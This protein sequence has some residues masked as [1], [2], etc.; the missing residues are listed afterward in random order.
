M[1][2]AERR[3]VWLGRQTAS[4]I[5]VGSVGGSF[6]VRVVNELV[7]LRLGPG[8]FVD[9]GVGLDLLVAVLMYSAALWWSRPISRLLDHGEEGRRETARARFRGF[10][11]FLC[12]MWA[13]GAAVEGLWG[14]RLN[15]GARWQ[16]VLLPWFVGAWYGAYFSVLFM[17]PLLIS[18]VGG[19]LYGEPEIFHR[20]TGPSWSVRAKLGLLVLNLILVPL[21]LVEAARRA[22]VEPSKTAAMV[23]TTLVFAVGYLEVLY[24]GITKPLDGLVDKMRLVAAGDYS[25]KAT[26]LDDDEIGQLK[27]YFNDMVDGLAERERIK[28]TFGR[29]VSVEVAK[30]LIA[31]GTVSLGGESIEATVLFSDIRDFTP[32]CEGLPPEELVRLLNSYFSFVAEPIMENRGMVNKFIGDAVMAVFAKQFGSSEH[33]DDAVRAALGMRERLA[34]FNAHEKRDL[35]FGVGIHTGILVAG[36]I[37]TPKRLE[38]TVIG[39]TVNIAS[40]IESTNKELGSVI[41]V[42][43]DAYARLSPDLRASLKATRR[44]DIRLKGKEKPVALWSI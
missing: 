9:P 36:N 33:P 8:S 13:V 4:A 25:A 35:R 7:Y 2:D 12:A 43:E 26:V 22:G 41:L 29:F 18:Q 5:L 11:R 15:P 34:A 40:R 3:R 27:A 10:F 31:S 16:G 19:R 28:D 38:Y 23:L 42:S 21:A 20:K 30:K 1:G 39:D 24:R 32:L 37:G 44:E 14:W 6:F 17:E